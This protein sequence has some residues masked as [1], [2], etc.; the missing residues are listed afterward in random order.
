M[1]ELAVRED[2]SRVRIRYAAENLATLRKIA[3]T[4]LRQETTSTA[5]INGKRLICG[6]DENYLVKVLSPLAPTTPYDAIALP[7]RPRN[8]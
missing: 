5:S 1:L 3:L 2:E 4:L 7:S 6:W 8:C